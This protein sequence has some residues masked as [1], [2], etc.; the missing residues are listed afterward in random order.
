MAYTIHRRFLETQRVRLNVL[1]ES[2][3]PKR[4]HVSLHASPSLSSHEN[5]QRSASEADIQRTRV[6]CFGKVQQVG[7][8]C[9]APEGWNMLLKCSR[10]CPRLTPTL[11]SIRVSRPPLVSTL[12]MLLAGAS[13]SVA[14]AISAILQ[15]RTPSPGDVMQARLARAWLLVDRVLN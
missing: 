14:S 1:L 7:T 13:S 3:L 15:S 2:V 6:G 9:I 5:R 11:C 4:T 12:R 8:R 10:K